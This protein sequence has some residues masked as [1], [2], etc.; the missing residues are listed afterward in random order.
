MVCTHDPLNFVNVLK[1]NTCTT[2]N[3][4]V[5]ALVLFSFSSQAMEILVLVNQK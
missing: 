3:I 4:L 1:L 5:L 2:A